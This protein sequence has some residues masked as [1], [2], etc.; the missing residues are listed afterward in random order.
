MALTLIDQDHYREQMETVVLPA[1]EHCQIEGWMEPAKVRDLDEQGAPS[2][3]LHY[4]CYD[5]QQFDELNIPG[6][7]AQF[8]GTVVI[9][10]GFTEF[11]KKYAELIWYFLVE[12]YSVCVLEHRGHGYSA[13]DVENPS[14]VWID[15][16]R[17][18]VADMAQF[19]HTVA[20]P[21]TDGHP[22]YFFGHSM[23]GG[24][25]AAL[26]EQYPTLFDR[27][28]L[29]C[30]MIAPATGS[31]PN[32]LA[33]FASKLMCDIG[34]GRNRVPGYEEF[35]E[36]IDLND[37]PR[38]S[39]NRIMWFHQQR[40]ED[41]HY[42]MFAPTFAWVRQALRLSH[43]V[44]KPARC[45]RIETPILMFQARYDQ[46]VLNAAE[47]RFAEQVRGSGASTEV[48]RLEDSPHE[49]LSTPNATLGPFLYRLFDYLDD[50]ASAIMA[51]E[52]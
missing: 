38:T 14:L 17:R 20:K 37:Y 51:D 32:W 15:D 12:G 48:V 28:I 31:I 42:Q 33:E 39:G 22:L 27:A 26:L 46:W 30:P 1:L 7:V 3:K 40:C 21:F 23:G 29:S 8:R 36:H 50:P 9:A 6:A 45:D 10:H 18:Y 49:I 5:S 35:T 25:G 19:S 52:A 11:A 41:V 44:L 13:R 47:N 34:R 24:I 2:G 16:W 4:L 43:E